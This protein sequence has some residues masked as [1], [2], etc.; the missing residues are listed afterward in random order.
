MWK[1]S[2]LLTARSLLLHSLLLS[3]SAVALGQTPAV[4][5]KTENWKTYSSEEGR[6]SVSFPGTPT[7]STEK[8][9]IPGAEFVLSKHMLET[10]ATYGVIFADYPTKFESEEA[11]KQ[12]LLNAAKGAAAEID[13]ELLENTE[14]T[15]QGNPARQLKERLKNGAIM[16]VK[17]ILV[18]HQRLYQVAITLPAPDKM[19]T[20]EVAIFDAAAQQFLSSFKLKPTQQV[21]G[22]VDQWIKDNNGSEPL[23]GTCLE[24]CGAEDNGDTEPGRAVTLAKPEYPV[25]ARKAG[26]SGTVKVQVIIDE[27]GQ[28]IAAQVLEGHPL[29]HATSVAAA[30]STRFTPTKY[31]GQPAKVIGVV[32]YHF[33]KQ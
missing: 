15:V 27:Q 33:T 28:I 17:M 2:Q 23:Y 30:K 8:L 10:R 32:D 1:R 18:D 11:R 29:L 3:I 16:Q 4:E 24:D 5:S 13:S 14:T 26:V 6:F 19:S 20:D 9:K 22:E 25:L 7:V 12:L 31:K 21:L